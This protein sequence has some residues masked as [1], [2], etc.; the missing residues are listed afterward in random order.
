ME[1]EKRDK[2]TG[3]AVSAGLHAALLL[4]FLVVLAW[5]EPFPPH[6]EYGIELNFGMEQGGQGEVQPQD[7]RTVPAEETQEPSPQ[8]TPQEQVEE[9]EPEPARIVN[10]VPAPTPKPTE[11]ESPVRATP[12][13]E[14]PMPRPAEEKKPTETTRTPA[15]EDTRQESKAAE[16]PAVDTKALYP[17]AGSQGSGQQ[18]GDAG[19][20][21]GKVDARALYGRPGG[22]GGGPELDLAGWMW[23]REPRP[24]DRSDE[25]GRIV[26][27]IKVNNR[28]EVIGIRTLEKTVSAGVE[29]V[30]RREVEKLS[31]SP[32]SENARPAAVTTGKITF[33][34]RSN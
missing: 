24:D 15:A 8:E 30:Y 23:D 14:K 31:F 12:A 22:G 5:K 13:E 4:L 1:K 2:A 33:I 7:N 29:Q 17:T 20:P 32:T 26:F 34:I 25:N 19:D 18:P 21:Q 28:G 16:K 9:A 10:E 6:P 3:W 11:S 27:E